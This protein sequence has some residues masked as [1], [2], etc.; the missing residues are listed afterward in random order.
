M[1]LESD[2]GDMKTGTSKTQ[3]VSRWVFPTALTLMVLAGT[4]ALC[5]AAYRTA[6]FVTDLPNR[7]TIDIDG[8]GIAQVINYSVLY[9]LTEGEDQQQLEVLQQIAS[10]PLEEPAYRTWVDQEFGEAIDGLVAH[11]D[12]EI[13]G[14][15]ARLQAVLGSTPRREREE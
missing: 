4:L 11:P 1:D 3:A 10:G 14:H 8:E 6:Q 13:A 9:A 5:W 12:L 7:F 2:S 15:A